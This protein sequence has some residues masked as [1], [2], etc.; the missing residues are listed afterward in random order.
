MC[1]AV[2]LDQCIDWAS[3]GQQPPEA[4]EFF[5]NKHPWSAFSKYVLMVSLIINYFKHF[6][7]FSQ[8]PLHI[9]NYI[10]LNVYI[11]MKFLLSLSKIS[12]E[13]EIFT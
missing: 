13:Q 10:F 6:N 3:E 9:Y 7:C 8:Y 1:A 2:D 12:R 5:L 4:E 11:N